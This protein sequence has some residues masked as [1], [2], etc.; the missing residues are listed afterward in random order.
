MH[1]TF[2][3]QIKMLRLYFMFNF[4]LNTVLQRHASNTFHQYTQPIQPTVGR[5]I[6]RMLL[7]TETD[8]P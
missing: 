4:N 6:T 2:I 1:M 8:N 5:S 3:N 7:I